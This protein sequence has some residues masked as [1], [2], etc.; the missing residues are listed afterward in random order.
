MPTFTKEH[1]EDFSTKLRRQ[2]KDSTLPRL[3]IV[4]NTA[5]AHAIQQIWCGD[6][7]I[8]QFGIKHGSKRNAPHG[9]VARELDLRP[10]YAVEFA[11]CNVTIDAMLTLFADRGWVDRLDSDGTKE[12]T[13]E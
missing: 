3:Q 1:A 5:G 10:H 12:A 6:K 13:A 2:P 9:W 7:L 4:E 11:I 8:A